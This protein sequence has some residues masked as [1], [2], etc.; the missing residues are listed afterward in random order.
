MTKTCSKCKK[1]KDLSEYS[2]DKT[3]KNYRAECKACVASRRRLYVENN[4]DK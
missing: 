2:F 3:H 4:P 1:D